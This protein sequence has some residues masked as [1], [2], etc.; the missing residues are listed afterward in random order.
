MPGIEGNNLSVSE[1]LRDKRSSFKFIH[2]VEEFRLRQ[3]IH[4]PTHVHG[5]T[6]DLILTS[7]PEL[8]QSR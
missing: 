5:N 6:L 2:T 4:G 8:L 7:E 3:L 1:D